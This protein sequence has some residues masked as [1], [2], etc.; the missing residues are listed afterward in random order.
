MTSPAHLVDQ[1]PAFVAP[2]GLLGA[3]LP[4]R[5]HLVTAIASRENCWVLLRLDPLSDEQVGVTACL[6]VAVTGEH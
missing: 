5:R 1:A 4:S 3:F 2:G 6:V